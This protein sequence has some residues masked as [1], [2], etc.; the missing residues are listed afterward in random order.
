MTERLRRRSKLI[1]RIQSI[2]KETRATARGW[3]GITF[4]DLNANDKVDLTNST[5]DNEIIQE[6]HY[7]AFG[8]THEGPWLMN[9]STKDNFYQYNGKEFNNDH[10]LNWNDYGARWY[11]PAVGRFTSIDELSDAPNNISLSPY[12]YVA[13]NPIVNIDPDGLDWYRND[14]NGETYWIEGN[15][16][17]KGHTNLGA[18]FIVEGKT[19]YVLH[20]QNE[21]I[22]TA[23]KDEADKDQAY[24]CL[25]DCGSEHNLAN[26]ITMMAS[27]LFDGPWKWSTLKPILCHCP[28]WA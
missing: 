20:Y 1:E 22:A 15:E 2:V 7:Y 17:V 8:M 28:K 14:E 27:G 16:D 13:N 11:D 21:V 19:G 6:N 23:S 9:H 12:H 10:A 24:D 4:A 26:Q 3:E 18:Y 25:S 5:T